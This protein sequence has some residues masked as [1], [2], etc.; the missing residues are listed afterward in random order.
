MRNEMAYQA[1]ANDAAPAPGGR[2][3]PPWLKNV[4]LCV[5][6]LVLASDF[7]RGWEQAA[8]PHYPTD[9]DVVQ[10]WGGAS[11]VTRFADT[12]RWWTGPWIEQH[13]LHYRPI[14]SYLMW[15]EYRLAG[16]HET[17]WLRVNL[18]LY[19]LFVLEIYWL[20]AF[21][22][23]SRWAGFIAGLIFAV[24][25]NDF[26]WA[27]RGRILGFFPGQ[28]DQLCGFS[29]WPRWGPSRWRSAARRWL[30][31]SRSWRRR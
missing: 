12:V 13:S 5:V 20:G 29:T 4:L 6:L 21:L 3:V 25:F 10:I 9:P 11:E 31:A 27:F 2:P 18:I 17:L 26:G 23:R 30:T 19:L 7:G 8:I 24:P 1:Q 28:T 16:P 14:V 15:A 22:F